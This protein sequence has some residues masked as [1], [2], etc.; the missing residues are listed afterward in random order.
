MPSA[1]VVD[2][3]ISEDI[4]SVIFV[5]MMKNDQSG[6]GRLG[7]LSLGPPGG[8]GR[9]GRGEG[10]GGKRG[11]EKGRRKRMGRGSFTSLSILTFA[12]IPSI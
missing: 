10:E 3:F 4:A 7:F 5:M 1:R 12:L 6:E 8:G 2:D 9:K 11:K